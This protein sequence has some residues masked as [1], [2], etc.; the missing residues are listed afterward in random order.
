[1]TFGILS[2]H[3][4]LKLV[5]NKTRNSRKLTN[6]WELSNSILNDKWFKTEVKKEIKHFLELNEKLI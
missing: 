1:M 6:S 3:H 4:E 2:D 5:I